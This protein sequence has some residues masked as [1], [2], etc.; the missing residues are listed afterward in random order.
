MEYQKKQFTLRGKTL[1]ELKKLSIREFAKYIPSR[2]RRYVLRNFSEI[3][4]FLKVIRDKKKKGKEIKTHHRD[5]VIVPEMVGLKI[6]I[7]NGKSFLPIQINEEMLGHRLGEF[8]HTRGKVKHTKAGVGA[9]KGSMHK[10]K[11]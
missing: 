7:Y 10:S 9:T 11:K 4:N 6:N 5:I 8:S 3:E 1:E 2:E